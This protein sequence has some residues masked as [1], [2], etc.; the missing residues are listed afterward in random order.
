VAAF[1]SKIVQK[2]AYF[3]QAIRLLMLKDLVQHSLPPAASDLL[4]VDAHALRH[5]M[6]EMPGGLT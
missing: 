4:R 5:A 6:V 1:S 3:E 2:T